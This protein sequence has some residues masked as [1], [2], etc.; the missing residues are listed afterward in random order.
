MAAGGLVELRPGSPGRPSQPAAPRGE[1]VLAPRA[2]SR[3]PADPLTGASFSLPAMAPG[4]R[5]PGP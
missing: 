2:S 5:E 4:Y 1:P 3:L